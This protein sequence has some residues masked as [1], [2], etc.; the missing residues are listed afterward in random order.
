MGINNFVGKFI[1][2]KRYKGVE[3]KSLPNHINNLF[4]DSNGI[5]HSAAAETFKYGP[6]EDSKAQEENLKVPFEQLEN[7]FISKIV[8]NIVKAVKIFNPTDFV[9]IS[10]DGVA[11][12]AK[13]NQQRQRRFKNSK[14]KNTNIPFDSNCITPGTLIMKKIDNAIS[15]YLKD[16]YLNLSPVIL[17]SSHDSPFEGEAKIFS[18]IRTNISK[19]NGNTVIYGLDADLIM[20]SLIS[21][22]ENL[23]LARERN[24]DIIYI[25]ALRESLRT[26]LL[27]STCIIDFVLMSFFIGNDFIP[28]LPSFDNVVSVYDKMFIAYRKLRSGLTTPDCKIDWNA[29]YKFVYSLSRE[30]NSLLTDIASSKNVIENPITKNSFNMTNG[31]DGKIRNVFDYDLYRGNYYYHAFGPKIDLNTLKDPEFI[32]AFIPSGSD[33]AEVC[34]NYINMINWNLH[35]YLNGSNTVNPLFYYKYNYSPLLSDLCLI[36][37]NPETILKDPGIPSD[38]RY[39][40]QIQQLISVIPPSSRGILPPTA[41]KYSTFDSPLYD[42]YFTDFKIDLYGKEKEYQGVSILPPID[43]NRILNTVILED[44]ELQ[45]Y[46]DKPDILYGSFESIEYVNSQKKIRQFLKN[47]SENTTEIKGYSYENDITDNRARGRGRGRARGRGRGGYNNPTTQRDYIQKPKL[48]KE[49][50]LLQKSLQP[51]FPTA[52]GFR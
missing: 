1:R 23:Y 18:Y 46:S 20:L 30:E 48:S 8:R 45:L 16:N 17:Y 15:G 41:L 33:I 43:P 42:L 28:R 39:F 49:E 40:N 3:L 2:Y 38:V 26:E 27:S 34:I 31:L 51:M 44:N 4:L 50:Y 14:N 6:F 32:N 24:N 13:I 7:I 36:L 21:P 35:Y 37:E 12:F 11:L 9:M 47:I 25:D 5:I 22:I 19:L 10:I 52:R 29:Y